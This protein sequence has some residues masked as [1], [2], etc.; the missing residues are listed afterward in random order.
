M[1]LKYLKLLV[2]HSPEDTE[3]NHRIIGNPVKV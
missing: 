3:E 1:N 2:Q